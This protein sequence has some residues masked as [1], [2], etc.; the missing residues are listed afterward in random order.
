ME[1]AEGPSPDSGDHAVRFIGPPLPY[2]PE[3][4][5]LH[6]SYSIGSCSA[7]SLLPVRRLRGTD[8]RLLL[9]ICLDLS[10][11][12][13]FTATTLKMRPLLVNCGRAGRIFVLLFALWFLPFFPLFLL[14]NKIRTGRPNPFCFASYGSFPSAVIGCSC[15]PNLASLYFHC[16]MWPKKWTRF[17]FELPYLSDETAVLYQFSLFPSTK[18]FCDYV[19]ASI[20]V[21]FNCVHIY[22]NIFWL[23]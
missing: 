19:P 2:S 18:Q 9:L 6:F 1:N 16:A 20:A 22:L 5:P 14:A 12:S 4:S 7:N 10:W 15:L 21:E 23:M 11:S 13:C 8:Y 17:Y 3:I